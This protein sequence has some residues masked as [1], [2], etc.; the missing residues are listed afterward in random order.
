VGAGEKW[1][2]GRSF[3]GEVN[4]ADG[5]RMRESGKKLERENLPCR[6]F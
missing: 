4:L 1:K 3:A 5:A 6:L 2:T